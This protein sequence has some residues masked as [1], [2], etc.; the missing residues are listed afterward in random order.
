MKFSKGDQYDTLYLPCEAVVADEND[1]LL[2][3]SVSVIV[4][5]GV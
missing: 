2:V 5:N 3:H 4:G 1:F